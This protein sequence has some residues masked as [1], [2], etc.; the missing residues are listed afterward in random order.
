[1]VE[2][3]KD[4]RQRTPKLW[5]LKLSGSLEV[6]LAEH[7]FW[8]VNHFFFSDKIVPASD[9]LRIASEKSLV[10]GKPLW[11]TWVGRKIKICEISALTFLLQNLN[12]N[13]YM[14][15]KGKGVHAHM[16]SC[17]Y[18]Q[19]RLISIR[20]ETY[21]CASNYVSLLHHSKHKN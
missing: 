12:N 21:I 10:I 18:W 19:I 1:M 11:K 15:R 5:R 17:L 6:M 20:H 3:T 9:N 8:G 2:V 16:N 7:S 14:C 4:I 13:I